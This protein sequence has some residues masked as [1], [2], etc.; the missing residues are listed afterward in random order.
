MGTK[1]TANLRISD[2]KKDHESN[3]LKANP[4]YQRF[5]NAWGPTQKGSLV[6]SILQNFP[7]GEIIRNLVNNNGI[8]DE[9]E[10]VDG[11]QR[12]TA[13]TEFINDE[14]A[15]N[16]ENSKKIINHY[17]RHFKLSTEPKIKKV[18]EKFENNENIRLKFK[19]LPIDLQR[20][21]ENTD[22]SVAT[23]VNWKQD[24]VIEYFRRVQ[25]GKPLTNADKLHTI[26]TKL[27]TS[28]KRIYDKEEG[29][30]GILNS[31][32]LKLDNKE[33]KKG[34]DRN[35]YQAVLEAV[36]VRLGKDLGQPSKLDSYFKNLAHTTDQDDYVSIVNTFLNGLS[37]SDKSLINTKSIKTDLKLI[38]CQLLFGYDKYKN[39]NVEDY[40]KFVIGCATVS[41]YLKTRNEKPSEESINRLV[42][43]LNKYDLMD[44]YTNNTE[45]FNEFY[46]LRA[47]AHNSA[48]VKEACDAMLSLY[49]VYQMQN[50]LE[51]V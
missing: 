35:I 31:L 21:I 39:C 40:K 3:I 38:F 33:P 16:D 47:G 7:I 9:Y 19:N 43:E 36:Y 6:V 5:N 18:V 42:Q 20:K 2:L 34:A 14:F 22:T 17:L 45:K 50:Q 44:I 24:D 8:S 4:T 23:L 15:L 49:E 25:E 37:T 32:G 41:G 28:I 29:N 13:I 10:I 11:L 48:K 1:N 26:K 30:P 51:L 46:K 27:T 12:I